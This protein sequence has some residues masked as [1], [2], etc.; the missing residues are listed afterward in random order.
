MRN[1]IDIGISGLAIGSV[2]KVINNISSDVYIRTDDN[3]I[4]NTEALNEDPELYA[5]YNNLSEFKYL[6]EKS[7]QKSVEYADMLVFLHSLLYNK[8]TE[9]T[10]EDR[11]DAFVYMKN[12]T[13]YIENML[14]KSKKEPNAR[15]VVYMHNIYKQIHGNLERHWNSIMAL[16]QTVQ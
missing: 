10:I 4:I 1:I 5:L 8:K 13:K 12:A 11:P 3:N 7:F 2:Y 15:N 6:D 9:P 14:M 16:T